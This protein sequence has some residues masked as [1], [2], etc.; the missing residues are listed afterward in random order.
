MLFSHPSM[1]WGLL[2]ILIPIAI[3]LFNLRRY[4]KVYFSNVDRLVGLQTESRRRS[5]LRRWLVLV[6]RVLA[7]ALLVLAFAGPVLPRDGQ[8][9]RTGSTAVSIYIDNSFSMEGAARDGS[10]LEIAKQKAREIAAAYS[11][12]D[13]YQLITGTMT[14]SQMRWL[15]RDELLSAID[16]VEP[17]PA[18]RTISEVATR[19]SAFLRQS[20]ASNRHAFIISDFQ[21]S[22]SDL[23]VLP[24]D[25][26]SLF[27]LVPLTGTATDNV[28]IDT[29]K[30]DAPAYFVGGSVAVEA[31]IINDGSNDIEKLPVKLYIN[32]HERAMS[33]LDIPAGSSGTATMLFTIGQAGWIDGYVEVADYP[34]TYDDK[35]FFTIGIGDRIGVLEVDGHEPNP[36]LNR[37]F[38][39]DS[40][41]T[42]QHSKHLSQ[43]EAQETDLII[44]NEPRQLASGDAT[45]LAEWV[46]AG[47]SLL[48]VPPAENYPDE[49]NTMLAAMQVPQLG[50]W[51]ARTAK[52][53]T[54]DYGNTL[55]SNVFSSRSD[56]M[57]M[58]SVQ[59]RYS[60][61]TTQ[62][63][64]QSVIT[65]SD[66]SDLLTA[67]PFGEGRVYLFTMPLTA[68]YTDLVGQALFVP[69]IYN[70]ALY[71]RPLPPPSYTLG[72]TE[73]IV[74]Q[75]QYDP[76]AKPPELTDGNDISII[77]D[78]RRSAGR[79][80]MILH[81]ELTSAGIYNL[82]DEHIAFNYGRRESRLKFM[83]PADV[84]KAID[85]RRG[86]SMLQPASRPLDQ[87]LRDREGGRSLWRLCL[88]FALVALAAEIALLK[89]KI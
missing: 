26:T 22:I 27:T 47:G 7:V 20:G 3:H 71:S 39:Y 88:I 57:E 69:T 68:D 32:G 81:G 13:R 5:E 85:G 77:P 11:P 16:E 34:I 36:S 48:V 52:A 53:T 82:A 75:G 4:R 59:A 46:Q 64:R 66:G 55:Y 31:T 38:A 37:L 72:S 89:I 1:L 21:Q 73:P 78:I 8:P 19:Q 25:S 51:T 50:R 12:S 63:I 54:I 67:T 58:P 65:L 6:A 28:Y 17:S 60:L 83:S 9:M 45:W 30:L 15:N 14:G 43:S 2:A 79:Q 56:E 44:L 86:Y 76:S 29:L 74:L 35:Y 41:I 42:F 84:A 70:M 62:A 49:L 33:T 23:D 40:T 87:T 24:D 61:S 18:V 80:Q 10:Q